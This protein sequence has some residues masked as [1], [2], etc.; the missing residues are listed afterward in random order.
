[1][2]KAFVTT[3]GAKRVRAGHLWIY[4][5]DLQKTDAAGGDVVTVFDEAKNA[6]G[7]A[8][9]SDSSEIAL[10]FFTTDSAWRT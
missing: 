10:R 1:M 6:V 7:Q 5:S 2:K 9:Y 8:F 3:R 4:K